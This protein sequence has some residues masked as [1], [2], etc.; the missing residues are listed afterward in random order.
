MLPERIWSWAQ[1][2]TDNHEMAFDV[3]FHAAFQKSTAYLKWGD[4]QIYFP[5]DSFRTKQT[6]WGSWRLFWRYPTQVQFSAVDATG[7]YEIELEW[8][9]TET[10]TLWKYP[11]IV[12]EQA[13]RFEG[14]LREYDAAN[15]GSGKML[16]AIKTDGFCEFTDR[17]I[18]GSS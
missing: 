6:K 3:G 14:A 7:K 1:F 12:F 15:P 16:E 9:V 17:W 11:L 13:C 2:S 10:S 4:E 18:G 5:Q 8:N